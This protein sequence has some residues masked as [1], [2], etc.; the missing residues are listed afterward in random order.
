MRDD[1]ELLGASSTASGSSGEVWKGA[2]SSNEFVA[3]KMLRIYERSDVKKLMK[4]H[5]ANLSPSERWL[6]L[7]NHLP[8][9]FHRDCDMASAF[10]PERLAFRRR[11]AS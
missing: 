8:G 6:T 9:V 5:L 1:I 10:S 7:D 2:N 3:V 11:L 4:V